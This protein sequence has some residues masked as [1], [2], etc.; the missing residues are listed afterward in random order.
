TA[1]KDALDA[2]LKLLDEAKALLEDAKAALLVTP[3]D[4]AKARQKIDGA[5]AKIKEAGKKLDSVQPAPAGFADNV[6]KLK[7][8]Y[9]ELAFV[10][11]KLW[12]LEQIRLTN[13]HAGIP[14]PRLTRDEGTSTD[15]PG[16]DLQMGPKGDRIDDDGWEPDV[17]YHELDHWFLY[18]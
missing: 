17:T 6:E 7:R 9:L 14:L 11:G 4:L 8:L 18:Q 10:S 5:R 15:G 16:G 12:L 13:P 1:E 2:A 3:P